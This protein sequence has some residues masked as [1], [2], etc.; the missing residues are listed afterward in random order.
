V[1][2]SNA[3]NVNDISRWQ[4]WTANDTAS[5][6]SRNPK[7]FKLQFSVDG[8]NYITVDEVTNY[9]APS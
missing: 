7:S 5:Y 8:M 1:G 3:F 9:S 6:P 4:W 2:E